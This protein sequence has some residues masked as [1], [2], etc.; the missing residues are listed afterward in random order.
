MEQLELQYE[1]GLTDQFPSFAHCISA[2]VYG[3]G[4]PFKNI[5][6]DLDLTSSYLSRMLNEN[7]D[8]AN[9]PLHRLPALIEATG[10]HRPIY[11]LV[12]QFCRSNE[13]KR[14][15]ALSALAEML[16]RIEKLVRQA[17]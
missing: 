13:D 10:D 7:D 9:F 6:A 11:W 1:G 16:P 2:A 8:G 12:E 4:K 15:R 3:C 14:E 17:E 5:A